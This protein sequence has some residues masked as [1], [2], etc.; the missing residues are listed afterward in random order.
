[1]LPFS[2]LNS[3]S[4]R[5]QMIVYKV[6]RFE[7]M[8]ARGRLAGCIPR[9]R[10]RDRRIWITRSASDPDFTVAGRDKWKEARNSC[11]SL[12]DGRGAREKPTSHTLIFASSKD[13]HR[14]SGGA[15][16]FIDIKTRVIRNYIH[17]LWNNML[18]NS[19]DISQGPRSCLH[20]GLQEDLHT[21]MEL[22]LRG[23]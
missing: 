23:R 22:R 17:S 3:N 2:T 18:H 19:E 16:E 20:E 1:M 8:L 11:R 14:L 7:L 6:A 9:R 12:S 4:T 13:G 15:L 5:L 10:R 21:S